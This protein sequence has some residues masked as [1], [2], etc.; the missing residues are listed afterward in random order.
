MPMASTHEKR[1]KFWEFPGGW[2]CIGGT[3]RSA[4]TSLL[5]TIIPS[6]PLRFLRLRKSLGVWLSNMERPLTLQEYI[7][8]AS[9]ISGGALYHIF[10]WRGDVFQNISC[11]PCPLKTYIFN[12]QLF[13]CQHETKRWHLLEWDELTFASFF[14]L[15]GTTWLVEG[16]KQVGCS[17]D[18]NHLYPLSIAI[19]DSLAHCFNKKDMSIIRKP[20]EIRESLKSLIN[21]PNL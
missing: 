7:Y 4:R 9:F 14:L 12:K 16:E 2:G 8:I 11:R 5:H 21:H 18:C 6:R 10:C 20:Y 3:I 1:F 17:G 19:S 13:S 15:L